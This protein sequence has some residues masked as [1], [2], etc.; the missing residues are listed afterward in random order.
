M[1]KS[2]IK[3]L[4][5]VAGL[6]WAGMACAVGFGSASVASS[7]GQP[8]K[9]EISLIA[10]S[11]A[12]KSGLTA[13]MASPD[14]FKAAGLDYPYHL[15]KLKFEIESRNGQTYV[16]VT[17]KEAVNDSFINLLVELSWSSGRLL[18]EYTFLL[19]PPDYKAEQP[20]AEEV[21]PIEPVVA[22]APP[23]E[24]PQ[25][26]SLSSATPASAPVAT[27][28]ASAPSAATAGALG[29][30]AAV[31]AASAPVAAAPAPSAAS[32]A[33]AST[34]PEPAAPETSPSSTTTAVP[35]VTEKPMVRETITVKRGDTLTKIALQIRESDVTLEQMLVALYR[36]NANKFDGKNMNRLRAGK[37]LSVPE[38]DDLE[39]LSQTAAVKEIR[40]HTVNWNAYRQK[41]A[42]A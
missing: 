2:L 26:E 36:A 28:S 8:L 3:T 20:K 10:V 23:S 6:V 7:L 40:I 30:E 14:A 42:A 38:Q 12:D 34:A 25:V 27:E 13:R 22:A 11:D 19:D 39:K 5:F 21:T 35:T 9:V 18:R 16:K 15:S 29:T 31:P 37:I 41:L 33:S 4:G 17:S 24:A 1:L 32:A